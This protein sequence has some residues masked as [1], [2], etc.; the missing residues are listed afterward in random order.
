MKS[1]IFTLLLGTVFNLIAGLALLHGQGPVS[2]GRIQDISRED[3]ILR[4]RPEQSGSG[5]ITYYG[6]DKADIV[7]VGGKAVKLADLTPGMQVSVFYKKQDERWVVSKILIPDASATPSAPTGL[8]VVP[9]RQTNADADG[10][11]TTRG[12]KS[13]VTDAD[14]TTVP[15][16]RDANRDADRTTRAPNSAAVDGDRTTVPADGGGALRR[17]GP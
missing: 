9:T 7:T 12:P 16:E 1:R 4:L 5:P 17:R 2:T 8:T 3:G 10:D 6:M 11:R 15:A 13:S 14:R